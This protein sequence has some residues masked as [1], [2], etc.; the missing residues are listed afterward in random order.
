[1]NKRKKNNK[2]FICE[3]PNI[4]IVFTNNRGVKHYYC[5][6]CA[7]KYIVKINKSEEVKQEAMPNFI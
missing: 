7:K 1:M 4:K 2:C 3:S 5:D 6:K